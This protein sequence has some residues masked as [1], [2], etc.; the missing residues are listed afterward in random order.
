MKPETKKGISTFIFRLFLTWNQ[1]LQT[2]VGYGDGSVGYFQID[3]D[4]KLTVSS[5]HKGTKYIYH[6][7]LELKY[8]T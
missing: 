5:Q 2:Y 3:E 4:L 6:V 8:E 1:A 7:I